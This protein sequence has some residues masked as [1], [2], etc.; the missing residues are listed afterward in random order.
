MLSDCISVIGCSIQNKRKI[1][2]RPETVPYVPVYF[3][4]DSFDPVSFDR[5]SVSSRRSDQYPVM[6]QVILFRYKTH[7]VG[8]VPHP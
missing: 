4:S 2:S 5:I 3:S 8:A 1:P 6:R 7:S